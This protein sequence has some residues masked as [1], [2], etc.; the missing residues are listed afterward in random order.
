ML[1]C[2]LSNQLGLD[3]SR[4]GECCCFCFKMYILLYL[5]IP[6][7]NLPIIVSNNSKVTSLTFLSILL[8]YSRSSLNTDPDLM[9]NINPRFIPTHSTKLLPLLFLTYLFSDAQAI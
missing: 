8:L 2:I 1:L 5:K 3:Y 6:N 4:G 9:R 7:P